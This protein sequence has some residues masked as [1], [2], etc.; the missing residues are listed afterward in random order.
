M[1]GD[2]KKGNDNETDGILEKIRANCV[3]SG[4]FVRHF[5]QEY[6]NDDALLYE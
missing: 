3:Q 2:S 5:S 4:I 6:T 1:M